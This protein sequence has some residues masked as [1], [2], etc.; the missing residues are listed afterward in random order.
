MN[1]HKYFASITKEALEDMLND[2]VSR[3]PE[4]ACGMLGGIYESESRSWIVQSAI[5]IANVHPTPGTAFAFD[6]ASWIKHYFG[7]T[8]NRQQFAGIYHSH[9]S[10][11]PV[12]SVKDETG[13]AF[14][15]PELNYWIISFPSDPRAG[16]S[17]NLPL[18]QPYR[19]A[20][21]AFYPV[22]LIIA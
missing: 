21:N 2:C 5:P 1:R 10:A 9:P 3:Y 4:E 19:F 16:R 15:Q 13:F 18:V 7:M 8:N 17:H 22:P 14:S 12:P 20:D 6:P 11:P